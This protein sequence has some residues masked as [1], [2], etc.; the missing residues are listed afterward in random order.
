MHLPVA[1]KCNVSCNFCNRKY[2]CI[3]ESRPG[4]TSV[5]LSPG[6][7]VE[8]VNRIRSRKPNIMV[9]GIAGPGDPMATPELTKETISKIHEAH[10]DMNLCLSTNGLNLPDHVD[11]LVKIGVTHFTVTINTVDP[12][13]ASKIY[14]WIRPEKL[15]VR[16]IK[17]GRYMLAQQLKAIRKLK[18]HPQVI[19]KINCVF[20]PGVNDKHIL[21][22]AQKVAAMGADRFNCIPLYPAE[23]SVFENLPKANL[24]ELAKVRD[25]AE[26]HLPQ[27]KY[28]ARCRA[29]AAG[30]LGE[31]TDEQDI[32]TLQNCASLPIDPTQKRPY[33]AVGSM[34]GV[35]INQ[36]LGEARDLWIFGH[37]NGE[38]KVIANRNT[39]PSGLGDARWN[40]LAETLKDCRT[41]LTSGVGPK[42]RKILEGAGLQ[43]IATEGMI[44]PT[45]EKLFQGEQIRIIK[46]CEH[47]CGSGCSGTGTGCG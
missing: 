47:R 26:T 27:M 42:P 22:V 32:E 46:P 1:P 40:S 18:R 21:E 11:D 16:G 19:L 5:V 37:E 2:D 38:V 29:D 24:I 45:L 13:I 9:A 14:A 8:A 44:K 7:A 23:G 33:I 31:K 15:A 12:E 34:E 17:A 28:C 20:I 3:N 10:P 35:I 36:H 4:V 43:V 39:P 41:I 30:L 25:A 6:Q